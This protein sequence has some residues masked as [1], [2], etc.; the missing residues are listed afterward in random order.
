MF[1]LSAFNPD[2]VQDP[3]GFQDLE[4]YTE[5]NNCFLY[6]VC[7]FCLSAD[8]NIFEQYKSIFSAI[9]IMG[10]KIQYLF[11]NLKILSGRNYLE[12][13]S[14]LQQCGK[15]SKSLNLECGSRVMVTNQF[16]DTRTIYEIY[17]VYKGH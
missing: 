13:L 15:Y 9:L 14:T 6:Q 2:W 4:A 10:S 12:G 3:D 7:F 17:R 5:R 11:T 1:G 16:M 8:M